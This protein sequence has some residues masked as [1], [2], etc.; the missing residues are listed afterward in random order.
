MR[1]SSLTLVIP[2]PF[3]GTEGAFFEAPAEVRQAVEV[4]GVRHLRNRSFLCPEQLLA[5][6]DPH[7]ANELRGRFAKGALYLSGD[8][9]AG[10]SRFVCQLFYR[11][12]G[13]G[14]VLG[15]DC[16][17]SLFE[18]RDRRPGGGLA[19]DSPAEVSLSS[20]WRRTRSCRWVA[21]GLLICAVCTV[22][23]NGLVMCASAPR[24]SSSAVSAASFWAVSITTGNESVRGLR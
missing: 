1:G 7:R 9:A 8:G 13:V 2:R 20:D 21:I 14:D 18:R 4:D 22:G 16:P 24:S 5:K 11:E 15:N 23:T 12:V 17:H 3:C 19:A 6:L 10:K